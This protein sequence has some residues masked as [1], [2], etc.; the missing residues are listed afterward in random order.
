MNRRD[1]VARNAPVI[2]SVP[3]QGVV[4]DAGNFLEGRA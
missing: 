3:D 1:L 2:P 4:F